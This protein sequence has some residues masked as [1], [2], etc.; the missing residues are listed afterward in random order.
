ME[1][2]QIGQDQQQPVYAGVFITCEENGIDVIP[3]VGRIES[4]IAVLT[5]EFDWETGLV[6]CVYCAGSSHKWHSKFV[7][8]EGKSQAPAPGVQCKIFSTNERAQEWLDE[9]K[10][11]HTGGKHE[12]VI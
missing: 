1:R 11:A 4:A 9:M 12:E 3:R 5:F 8:D 6:L 7:V 2:K 10:V